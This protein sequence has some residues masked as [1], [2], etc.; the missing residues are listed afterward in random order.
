VQYHLV[1][2][3]TG[4]YPCNAHFLGPPADCFGRGVETRATTAR[5]LAAGWHRTWEGTHAHRERWTCPDCRPDR[6]TAAPAPGP[7]EIPADCPF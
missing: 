5:A 7:I 2:W 4:G 3:C 6:P 1:I